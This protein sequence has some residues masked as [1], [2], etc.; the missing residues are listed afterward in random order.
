MSNRS[1]RVPRE[2]PIK[3][4]KKLVPF[5]VTKLGSEDDPCFGKLY[6]LTAPECHECG[7][8]ELCALKLSQS[9]RVKTLDIESKMS[10]RDISEKDIVGAIEYAKSLIKKHGRVIAISRASKMFGVDKAKIKESLK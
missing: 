9:Q 10:F 1:N 3:E 5:D 2:T 7:D 4:S 8:I 6:D